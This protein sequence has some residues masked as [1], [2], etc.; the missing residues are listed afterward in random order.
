MEHSRNLTTKTCEQ[1]V[2]SFN[3]SSPIFM[4]S[5]VRTR[6]TR[7]EPRDSLNILGKKKTLSIYHDYVKKNSVFVIISCRIQSC[8]K[9]APINSFCYQRSDSQT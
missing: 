2:V 8:K 6:I 4:K 7:E 9:I 3:K 1:N 5:G